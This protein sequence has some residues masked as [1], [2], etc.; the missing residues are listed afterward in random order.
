MA[1]RADRDALVMMYFDLGMTQAEIAFTLAAKHGLVLSTRQ[2]RR[3]LVRLKCRRRSYD[4]IGEVIV[5]IQEELRGSGQ[6]KGYRMMTETCRDAGVSVRKEDVR[7]ILRAL[8]PEG[9][10]QRQSRRLQRRAYYAKGPNYIWHF[11]GYDKLKP[12]GLC[13]SGCIDGFSRRLIWTTVHHTNNDPHVVGGYFLEAVRELGGAP[14]RIR[15]DCGTENGCVRDY[16]KLLRQDHQDEHALVPYKN[17][18][19]TSNQRIESFWCMLL[20]LCTHY[21]IQYFKSMQDLDQH[22]GGFLDKGLVQFCFTNIL[23]SELDKTA[24]V[25]NAHRIRPSA[26]ESV[27]SGRPNV[28]FQAPAVWG[29][30]DYL[31][32]VDNDAM[33][34]CEEHATFRSD[35]QC[36]QHIHNMCQD[37]ID[38]EQVPAITDTDSA[39]RQYLYLRAKIRDL[40]LDA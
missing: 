35:I 6:L 32:P 13:I 24:D 33:E 34:V 9:V 19:S 20:R 29:A 21:W 23:Q 36:H 27:P 16:Q 1:N 3:D 5:H 8:D 38:R 30:V 7:H 26:N 18:T 22:D 17:G 40:L 14:R 15:S 12:Y 37:I 10:T 2:L 39:L 4:D 31:C 25:W 11:D 28:I